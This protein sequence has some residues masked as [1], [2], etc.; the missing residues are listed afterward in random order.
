MRIAIASA[1]WTKVTGHAGRA[2]RWMVYTV[3]GNQPPA[4][5]ER[6]ELPADMVFHYFDDD[7]PHPLDGISVV[8]AQS[9]GEGFMA[10]MQKRGI[11]A[12]M[13][14]ENDP[15]AAVR[16]YLDATLPPPTPRPIGE[17]LCKA[18]DLFSKHK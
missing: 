14:G 6:V 18:F 3:D 13:T 16:E 11:E 5:P 15:A 17:L 8:I 1:D 7:R 9:A 12:R 2:R 10:R 4:P